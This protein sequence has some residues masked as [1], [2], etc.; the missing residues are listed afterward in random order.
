[1]IDIYFP[2]LSRKNVSKISVD[3]RRVHFPAAM[4]WESLQQSVLIFSITSSLI[5]LKALSL[6]QCPFSCGLPIYPIPLSQARLL[7]QLVCSPN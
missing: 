5:V 3:W 2:M 7:I 4:V 6:G 1:M